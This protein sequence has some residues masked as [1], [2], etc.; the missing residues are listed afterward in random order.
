MYAIKEF[1]PAGFAKRHSSQITYNFDVLPLEEQELIAESQRMFTREAEVICSL[2]H[3]NIVRGVEFFEANS[4]LYL[5]MEYVSGKT[6]RD[7]LRTNT[8]FRAD[9][10]TITLF[11]TSLCDALETVHRKN[12][13]HCDIKPDNIFLGIEFSPILI[14]FGGARISNAE[15]PATNSAFYSAIEQFDANN[16]LGPWTDIYGLSAVLYRCMTGGKLPDA[17]ERLALLHQT[18]IDSYEPV[19]RIAGIQA[20]YCSSLIQLVDSGL[21][22][23]P[24]ERPRTIFEW[25]SAAGFPASPPRTFPSRGF[26]PHPPHP[27][28]RPSAPPFQ[29]Q[30][31]NE[32]SGSSFLENILKIFKL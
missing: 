32:T 3:P 9:N 12:I 1:F 19:G 31:E 23:L 26:H 5:V 28:S 29:T 13:L 14:D 7:Q 17:R 8:E 4:T 16:T 30:R 6:L 25:R 11:C 21:R 27:T 24:R 22:L 10:K 2:N 15:A 18:G 20:S